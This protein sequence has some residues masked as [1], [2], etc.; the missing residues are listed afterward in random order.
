MH[1]D[2]EIQAFKIEQHLLGSLVPGRSRS[3]GSGSQRAFEKSTPEMVEGLRSDMRRRCPRILC[4]YWKDYEKTV[5][6]V[7]VHLHQQSLDYHGRDLVV[8]PDGASMAADGWKELSH[9]N[10]GKSQ[11]TSPNWSKDMASITQ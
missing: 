6:E 9:H 8:Y 1:A 11:S 3:Y 2:P 10:R 7:N 5:M 4:R